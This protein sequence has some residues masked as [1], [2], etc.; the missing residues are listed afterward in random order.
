MIIVKFNYYKNSLNCECEVLDEFVTHVDPKTSVL[1]IVEVFY[2]KEK[3]ILD[4]Y[5]FSDD[6][7]L[8]DNDEILFTLRK[9]KRKVTKNSFKMNEQTIT[10]NLFLICLLFILFS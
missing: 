4:P 8:D 1:D 9:K 7:N 2:S 10:G 5:D 6:E 3:K